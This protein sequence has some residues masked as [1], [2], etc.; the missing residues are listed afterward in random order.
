ML[1]FRLKCKCV[2]VCVCVRVCVC[3]CVCVCVQCVLVVHGKLLN[4]LSC[5]TSLTHNACPKE[6]SQA[7]AQPFKELFRPKDTS[8]HIHI[9]TEDKLHQPVSVK[10]VIYPVIPWWVHRRDQLLLTQLPSQLRQDCPT[11]PGQKSRCA[12]GIEPGVGIN[13][14]EGQ[15]N[16]CLY[17]DECFSL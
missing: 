1:A 17:F 8:L 3:V 16:T 6:A 10:E 2:C 12:A 15:Q 14:Y 7:E 11:H 5:E 9:G 13:Y 4:P